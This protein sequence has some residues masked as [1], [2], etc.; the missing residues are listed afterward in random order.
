MGRQALA[1]LKQLEAAAQ[2]ADDL[3]EQP[4]RFSATSADGHLHRLPG[5][6]DPPAARLL[7]EIGDDFNPLR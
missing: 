7:A 3:A 2:A 5:L 4:T 1:L 6:G